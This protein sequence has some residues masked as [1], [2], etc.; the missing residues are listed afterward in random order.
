M[1]GKKVKFEHNLRKGEI[2]EFII[3]DE[4]FVPIPFV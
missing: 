1:H 2:S 4:Q 3:V